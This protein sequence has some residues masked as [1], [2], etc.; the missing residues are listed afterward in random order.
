MHA[1]H[2]A[3]E[4]ITNT[5]EDFSGKHACGIIGS[6]PSTSARSPKVW[7]KVFDALEI[8]AHYFSFDVASPEGLQPLL[9]FLRKCDG[10]L[11]GNVTM[12]YKVAIMQ[13]LDEVD[14]KAQA[15]GAVNTYVRTS[16]GK[17]VGYNTDGQGA[18]DNILKP[19]ESEGPLVESL[20]GK[21]VLMIGAGGA[22][23]ASA[24]FLADE[25]GNGRLYLANRTKEKAEKLM[26]EVQK[27]KPNLDM[28]AL[29]ENEMAKI[30]SNVDVIF[31]CTTKGQG[32]LLTKER[33]AS[34]NEPFSALAPA[35]IP[36]VERGESSEE[37]FKKGY[38]EMAHL[39]IMKNTEMSLGLASKIPSST[40]FV[41][42]IFNPCESMFLRHGRWTGHRIRNG[43]GMNVGQAVAG[44][45]TVMKPVLADVSEEKIR[46]LMS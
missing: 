17:L 5:L 14:P 19:F 46:E 45:S 18:V 33:Q 6:N 20:D 31:N 7:N 38:I 34:Y 40:V 27:Y 35:D 1:V 36:Q 2:D 10:F 39:E 29:D 4:H 42:A 37:D 44:F 32:G 8:D 23:M 16:E 22:A 26:L 30:A 13:Y 28:E 9:D 15:I 12:P 11:G 24:F 21:Q 25:L 43:I 41:D 3:K